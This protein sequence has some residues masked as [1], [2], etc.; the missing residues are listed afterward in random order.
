VIQRIL[1]VAPNWIGDS[2]L[3]QPLLARLQQRYPA[4]SIDALA[5][6]WTSAVLQRMPQLR[7][8]ISTPFVHGPLQLR[9]RWQ[10]ARQLRQN[11]Y[12]LAVVLPNSLKAA[13]LPWFAGIPQRA[14]F[15]GES[16]YGLINRLHRLDKQAL[17]LMAERYAQLAEDPDNAPQRP[18]R[19]VQLRVDLANRASQLQRLG[20]QLDKPVSVFCPG[21]EFGPAKRWP[22]ERFAAAM[23][24]VA[25]DHSAEW[26][27]FGV[28]G[29]APAAAAIAEA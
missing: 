2:L 25:K 14:G 28:A 21:A 23:A 10:L 9:Q 20:L 29:D 8:V 1:I 17:P 5:P 16:R 15:V 27:I 26:I 13:L 4:A 11:D 19:A 7:Q 12:Q 3:A 24:A 22:A 6:A 18:L